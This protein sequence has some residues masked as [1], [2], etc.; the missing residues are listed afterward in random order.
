MYHKKGT[1]DTLAFV[2]TWVERRRRGGVLEVGC[3]E[4]DLAAALM[5]RGYRVL[6]VDADAAAVETARARGVDAHHASWPDFEARPADAVL[7]TRSLHH[8]DGLDGAVARAQECA[9]LLLIEDFAFTEADR[10]LIEWIRGELAEIGVP[11]D[12]TSHHIHGFSAMRDAIAPHFEILST[13]E[14][15]YC[16]RYAPDEHAARLIEGE[17]SLGYGLLGR[18]VVG[19]RW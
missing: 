6:A 9:P 8:I 7:F 10:R 17:R 14:V 19:R 1:L 16:Y 13:E 12:V 18:R 3:G 4:G 15:P 11:W 2:E 5:S